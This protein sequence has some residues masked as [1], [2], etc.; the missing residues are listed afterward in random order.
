MRLTE[1]FHYVENH[2][3]AI[4]Y[5]GFDLYNECLGQEWDDIPFPSMKGIG[6]GHLT[7]GE[8][9]PILKT[10]GTLTWS[11]LLFEF[12]DLI[13]KQRTKKDEDFRAF[14]FF[15]LDSND[16]VQINLGW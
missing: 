4:H 15:E 14:K 16:Y 12:D 2:A 6:G 10:T 3:S 8:G 9:Y 11:Q 13:S 7:N 1:I 5:N